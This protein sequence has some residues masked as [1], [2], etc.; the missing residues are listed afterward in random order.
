MPS[1]TVKEWAAEYRLINQAE[2]EELKMRL[3][4]EKVEDSVRSYFVLSK[5]VCALSGATDEPEELQESRAKFYLELTRRWTLL[6]KRMN[7]AL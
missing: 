2:R 6:A 3:P 5:F 7:H 4:Q 1:M